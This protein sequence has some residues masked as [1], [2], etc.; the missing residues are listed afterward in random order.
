MA[1][2]TLAT[3]RL[4]PPS[5]VIVNFTAGSPGTGE[6]VSRRETCQC[7]RAGFVLQERRSGG[8]AGRLPGRACW[9]LGSSAEGARTLVGSG[10][11]LE[12]VETHADVGDLG[13]A[14]AGGDEVEVV[15][16]QPLVR[17]AGPVGHPPKLVLSHRCDLGVHTKRGA[18]LE[19]GGE[20]ELHEA[21]DRPWES[22]LL[23]G[24]GTQPEGSGELTGGQPC[25]F[26]VGPQRWKASED[27]D[28]AGPDDG[29]PALLDVGVGQVEAEATNAGIGMG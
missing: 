19:P 1:S 12:A 4:A 9:C 22:V 26:L 28:A 17:R 21:L 3:S 24:A 14:T 2:T 16:Q 23:P 20:P 18:L 25:W 7:V 11:L 27:R 15:S 6:Q 5:G 13:A 29:A 10:G 8:G